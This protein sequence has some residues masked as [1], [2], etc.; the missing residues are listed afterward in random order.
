VFL[1]STRAGGLGINLTSADTVIFYDS[2]WN[3]T[4]DAQVSTALM[5]QSL[6]SAAF[7]SAAHLLCCEQAMDRCHRIGQTEDVTVYRL[8]TKG[9]IE[10]RILKRAQEKSKVHARAN[11]CIS[12]FSSCAQIQHLV[13]AGGT[14]DR[15]AL[16]LKPQEVRSVPFPPSICFASLTL[17]CGR[18]DGLA[19]P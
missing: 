11:L 9:T 14:F 13:I 6:S 8:V 4:N 18:V 19:A 16:A 3:P 1:L 5:K 7:L 2:D 12:L 15:S 10:E 17:P